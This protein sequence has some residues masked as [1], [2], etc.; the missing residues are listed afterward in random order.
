MV[1]VYVLYS[2]VIFQGILFLLYFT[3]KG[4]IMSLMW[5]F[6]FIIVRVFLHV[7]MSGFKWI[8]PSQRKSLRKDIALVTGAASGIGR[9]IAL[10]LASKGLCYYLNFN[11]RLCLL[12]YKLQLNV[13]SHSRNEKDRI[14]SISKDFRLK[15]RPAY[16]KKIK[17]FGHPWGW[18][19]SL[20]LFPIL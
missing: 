8:L 3:G 6:A 19:K 13:L 2:L 5:E 1:L 11:L 16:S 12:N 7:S 18:S 4:Y 10:R 15:I 20:L 9:L 17:W 14:G